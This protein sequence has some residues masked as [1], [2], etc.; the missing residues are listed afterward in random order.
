MSEPSWT[1]RLTAR[2]HARRNGDGTG[3]VVQKTAFVLA[4]G[5]SRGAVQ[6][7]MLSELVEQE[8]AAGEV[9][10]AVPTLDG[11]LHGGGEFAV[12]S[13][14]LLEEQVAKF[15]VGGTD[16][17]GVHEFFNVVIHGGPLGV[18]MWR[19]SACVGRGRAARSQGDYRRVSRY[20]ALVSQLEG[21]RFYCRQPNV[22]HGGGFPY[23]GRVT[24][25][26]SWVAL[27][28]DP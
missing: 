14:E 24:A 12:G 2:W 25:L 16:V 8:V 26:L 3:P 23:V 17:D 6:V 21:R 19:F 18:S 20:N 1:D 7:G 5:G 4:G 28:H 11:V 10:Y 22:G 27:W 13:A 15:N 9:V